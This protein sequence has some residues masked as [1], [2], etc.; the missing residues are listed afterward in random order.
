MDTPALWKMVWKS[1]RNFS[2]LRKVK[3]TLGGKRTTKS[4]PP[5]SENSV[6]KDG[7]HLCNNRLSSAF[8]KVKDTL[9]AAREPLRTAP[10]IQIHSIK[11]QKDCKQT[12]V[13]LTKNGGS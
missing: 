11:I 8:R 13:R 5:V 1:G 4:R 3:D 6:K 2:N 9:G 7:R 12:T 10:G